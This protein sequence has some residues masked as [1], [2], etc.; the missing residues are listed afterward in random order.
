MEAEFRLVGIKNNQFAFDDI[1]IKSDHLE[2]ITVGIAPKFGI[3][4]E[5]KI[6]GCILKIKF[7]YESQSFVFLETECH[8]KLTDN[9]W[10]DFIDTEN[11]HFPVEF[12]RH[13]GVI[14][15]GTMRGV[16]FE[17]LQGSD[18]EFIQLPLINLTEVID[19]E[20]VFSIKQNT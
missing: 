2:E 11:I 16:L 12:L 10:N 14:T 4:A 8:F 6:I 20:E 3:N 9:S 5:E 19:K 7:E 17:K 15:L 18:I 13:L 1:E